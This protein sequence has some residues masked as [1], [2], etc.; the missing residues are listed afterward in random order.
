MCVLVFDAY[1]LLFFLA[2]GNIFLFIFLSSNLLLFIWCFCGPQFF[3][4]LK[5]VDLLFYQAVYWLH[6]HSKLFPLLWATSD[7]FAQFF[8]SPSYCFSL[9]PLESLLCCV[10]QGWAK[11]CDGVYRHLG[12]PF[13]LWFP[14]SFSSSSF[15]SRLLLMPQ[16]NMIVTSFLNLVNLHS[17]G[18]YLHSRK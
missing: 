15:G 9:G 3:F 1:W 6:L 14:S 4:L 2:V 12:V 11:D 7:T 8:G 13:F 18:L 16:T 5:S 10:V 17:V